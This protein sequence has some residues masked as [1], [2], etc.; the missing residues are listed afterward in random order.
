MLKKVITSFIFVSLVF[1]ATSCGP[2]IVIPG[3][4]SVTRPIDD[5]PDIP[6][7]IS[8]YGRVGA[9]GR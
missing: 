4:I 9:N 1:I 2:Q 5:R 8:G 7:N 3:D 6:G